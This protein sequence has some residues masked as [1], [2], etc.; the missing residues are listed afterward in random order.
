MIR[1]NDFVRF[2]ALMQTL[3]EVFPG[4]PPSP[5][6]V[7][8]YFLAL[9]D[10]PY[11][12]I[13]KMATIHIRCGKFF[14]IPVELADIKSENEEIEAD[15]EIAQEMVDQFAFMGFGQTG[16]TIIA[17]KLKEIGREYLMTFINRNAM[18]IANSEN[19]TA[20]RAQLKKKLMVHYRDHKRLLI[21]AKERE[22]LGEKEKG[23]IT[24]QQKQVDGMINGIIKK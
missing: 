3:G 1:K 17:I 8:L 19:P 11:E 18:E 6:K 15:Y 10:L 21:E 14:P 5:E 20:T 24:D 2:A 7:E 13:H 16:S 9:K 22:K 4:D 23:Q 12:V